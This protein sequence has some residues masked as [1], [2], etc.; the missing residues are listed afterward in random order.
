[1][2]SQ[3]PLTLGARWIFPVDQPPLPRGTLTIQGQRI[4][5]VDEAGTRRPDV[6][7]GNV[8]ILPGFV[9][10]HTHLDLSDALGL[11][12]PSPD[13]VGWL[14]AVIAHRRRQTSKAVAT[15]IA[16]GLT[17]CRRYGTTLVGD[18]AAGGMSWD[19]LTM[20]P[21]RTVVFYEMLGLPLER[22]RPAFAAASAWVEQHPATPSCQPGLSPHAPYSVNYCL[23]RWAADLARQARLPLA[24]H[25]AETKA[26]VDLLARHSGPLVSFLENLG[27]WEVEGLAPSLGDVLAV[28]RQQEMVSFVH[29]NYLDPA[30]VPG[31]AYNI[32]CPRTHAA[33]GHDAHPFPAFQARGITVALGTDS[34]ASNPD[35]NVLAEARFLHERYPEVTG[36]NILRMATLNGASALGWDRETGS[37]TPGKSADLVILPLPD[38]ERADPH[39]L[40][41]ESALPI[42]GVYF[43]GEDLSIRAGGDGAS[44]NR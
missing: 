29:G 14:A 41:L 27:V 23:L 20:A 8:A 15:A 32:Y 22:A 17:Q 1:M 30:S 24:I 10:A 9:N 38:D 36:A 31:T 5:A 6:N 2:T 43:R 3:Q 42:A 40:V 4:L 28:A 13:F 18:I 35:L 37:L 16:T 33:F 25:V 12:P 34:L 26:E 39:A 44:V 11:C 7:L 21:M 19:S